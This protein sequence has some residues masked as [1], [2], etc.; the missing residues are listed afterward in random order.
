MEDQKT[1]AK[2]YTLTQLN[3][4]VTNWVRD[5]FGT[6]TYWISCE[7]AKANLKGVHWY[8]ELADSNNIDETTAK[9]SASIWRIN[10][11]SI[12]ESLKAYGVRP[13]EIL[14]QGNRVRIKVRVTFH[15]VYGLKL[16]I[17]E[18]DAS[19]T[20]GDI[21]KQKQETL[22]RIKKEGLDTLQKQLYLSPL[23]TRLAV[24]GSPDT[25]GF[26]DFVKELTNNN[27]FTQFKYKVFP[28]KVQGDEALS[29]IVEAINDAS[30][31]DVEAIVI[32]RGGGSKMDLHVFNHYDICKAIAYSRVPVITGIGHETDTA[33]V[34]IVSFESL[35][36]PTAA[37][38]RFYLKIATFRADISDVNHRIRLAGT[39]LI[40]DCKDELN[41]FTGQLVAIVNSKLSKEKDKLH[42]RT[43]N[44]N[45]A[46]RQLLELEKNNFNNTTQL[47][48]Q[49]VSSRLI[50]AKEN[51]WDELID[52]K[53]SSQQMLSSQSNTINVIQEKLV[54]H[55]NKLIEFNKLELENSWGLTILRIEHFIGNEKY[56]LG[57]EIDK[58]KVVDPTRLFEKGY[59][60]STVSGKDINIFN[61]ELVGKEMTTYSNKFEIKSTIK[62]I[63]KND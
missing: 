33:L 18:V 52:I 60:I 45:L 55:P 37:A 62:K 61:G 15:N 22:K 28:T 17:E 49:K 12:T 26:T 24:I 58:L 27:Y 3:Q 1:I 19:A 9:S 51:L 46:V 39:N 57:Y 13:E 6:R 56:A 31:H 59:T 54:S 7:V 25:S 16:D 29:K 42:N 63:N 47:F 11:V 43:I 8:L 14:K 34:D 2:T 5:A 20:L 35:K 36:T 10:T 38:K 23:A 53:S 41:Y 40:G 32:I 44:L 50:K 30:N 21:E 4:S 48:F